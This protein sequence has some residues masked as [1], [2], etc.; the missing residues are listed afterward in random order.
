[1]ADDKRPMVDYIN[2]DGR[3]DNTFPDDFDEAIRGLRYG[4]EYADWIIHLRTQL[5][6]A[7]DRERE[8]A[9]AEDEIE[10]LHFQIEDDM[11]RGEACDLGEKITKAG[12]RKERATDAII[13][14]H[15]ARQS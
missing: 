1:M 10:Q 9:E 13:A 14:A 6:Q 8:L 12:M 3:V 11:T 5:R 4:S 2:E 15:K 7:L